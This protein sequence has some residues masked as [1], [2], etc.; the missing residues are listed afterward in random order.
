LNQNLAINITF[1]NKSEAFVTKYKGRETTA[2]F[3]LIL[4][5]KVTESYGCQ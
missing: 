2:L 4:A 1:G 5:C 3:P